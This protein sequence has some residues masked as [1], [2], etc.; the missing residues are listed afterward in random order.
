MRCSCFRV[1]SLARL[2]APA[3]AFESVLM[4]VYYLI[5]ARLYGTLGSAFVYFLYRKG[6]SIH[7]PG[8]RGALLAGRHRHRYG[9]GARLVTVPAPVRCATWYDSAAYGAGSY[10]T[11]TPPGPSVPLAVPVPVGNR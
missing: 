9:T 7:R 6:P 10:Q 3:S 5:Y 4:S 2:L 1:K 11:A 8:L